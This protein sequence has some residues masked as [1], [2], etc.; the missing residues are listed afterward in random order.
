MWVSNSPAVDLGLVDGVRFYKG[1]QDTGMQ[2]GE[3][4]SSA[5]ALLATATFTAES[6]Q[7]LAAGELLEPDRDHCEYRLHH[8][9]PYDI[10]IHRVYA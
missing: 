1:V 6:G 8:C 3:L 2:I 4:W 9:V 10:A 7:R 5:G